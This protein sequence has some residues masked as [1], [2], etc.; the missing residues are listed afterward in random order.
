MANLRVSETEWRESGGEMRLIAKP[1]MGLLCWGA[2][3][4]QPVGLDHKAQ[5]GPKEVDPE[6]IHMLARERQRKTGLRDKW[7]KAPLQLRVGETKSAAV[8]KLSQSRHPRPPGVCVEGDAQGVRT[9][10]VEP[11]R[12]VD[13]ALEGSVIEADRK[14]NQGEDRLRDR[15][16]LMAGDVSRAQA[17]AAMN[18]HTSDAT[19]RGDGNRD[20]D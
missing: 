18:T 20:L 6:A 17:C 15:N 4:A 7:Q 14:V 9:D 5:L 19:L 10:Q 11:V 12:L 8:E 13:C 1:V 16:A 2:V 3:I